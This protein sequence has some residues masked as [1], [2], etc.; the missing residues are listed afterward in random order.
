MEN[1]EYRMCGKKCVLS[2]RYD[3]LAVKFIISKDECDAN[4]CVEGC[5]CK[6]GFLRHH[7]KCVPV[8]EC[9]ARQNKAM[10]FSTGADV[11]ADMQMKTKNSTQSASQIQTMN[12]DQ[13]KTEKNITNPKIFGFLNRPGCGFFGC[14]G[15]PI[16]IQLQQYDDSVRR[17]GN[18]HS[19]MCVSWI[20]SLHFGK[21]FE[22]IFKH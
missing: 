9:S 13:V 8:K 12:S 4:K 18:N 15:V 14:A 22:I 21:F 11:S 1:E 16:A 6:N 2:C 3:P 19:G 5:Y 10:N 7:K 17:K 20:F